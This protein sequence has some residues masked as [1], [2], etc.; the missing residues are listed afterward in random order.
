[1]EKLIRNRFEQAVQDVTEN[2][3]DWLRDEFKAILE[4]NKPYQSKCDHIGYSIA[5]I[6]DKVSLLDDEIKQIQEYKKKLKDAKEIAVTVGAGVFNTYGISKIEGGGISSITTSKAMSAS[7]LN[8]V[9]VNEQALIDGGFYKKVIDTAKIQK[10]YFDGDYK[11]FIEANVELQTITTTKPSKLR[12]N[13][14]RAINNTP[15]DSNIIIT[16]WEDEAS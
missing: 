1:M 13:K 9:V 7:K 14:R 2:R 12:I 16:D 6:D 3:K 11:E 8:I 4:S 10:S 5:S 15:F